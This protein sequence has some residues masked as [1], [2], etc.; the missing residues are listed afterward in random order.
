MRKNKIE[1]IFILQAKSFKFFVSLGVCKTTISKL[2]LLG[3][4]TT[5]TCGVNNYNYFVQVRT[6]NV[7]M[8]SVFDCDVI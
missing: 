6:F 2:C 3:Q 4:K 7:R 8:S 1:N 5:G